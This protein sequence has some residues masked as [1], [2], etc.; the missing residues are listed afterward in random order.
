MVAMGGQLVAGDFLKI[1][2]LCTMLNINL[3]ILNLLP[4]PPLDGGKIVFCLLEKIHLS[5]VKL[6]I[7]VTVVG[8]VLLMVLI[9]YISVIDI[10]KH[11][12]KIC[13]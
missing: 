13:V 7:P 12:F 1:L 5:L 2:Q 11:V 9:S 8:W 3:A 4:L 6:Q 10:C